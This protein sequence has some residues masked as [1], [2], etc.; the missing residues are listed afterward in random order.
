MLY[1]RPQ[2]PM[3][4]L[5]SLVE[6]LSGATG[7]YCDGDFHI[8]MSNLKPEPASSHVYIWSLA[9]VSVPPSYHKIW[10]AVKE[11]NRPH[12]LGDRWIAAEVEER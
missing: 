10:G 9:R 6:D 1:S 8:L 4:T 12:D 11:S 3:T 2:F 5:A 7:G